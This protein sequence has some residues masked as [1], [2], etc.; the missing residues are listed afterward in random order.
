MLYYLFEFLEQ[1]F[2]FPSDSFSISIFRAS[3]H[4]SFLCLYIDLWEDH[5]P[6]SK[7][8]QIGESVRDLDYGQNEKA[9][10]PTMG[11]V[12]IIL[13]TSFFCWLNWITFTSNFY[14]HHTFYGNHWFGR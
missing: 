13:D 11:G 1:K 12:I 3:R 4:Y 10:T 6:I 14:H 2:Q 7:S 5:H 8:K 9:G